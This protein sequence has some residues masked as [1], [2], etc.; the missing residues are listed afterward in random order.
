MSTTTLAEPGPL[1]LGRANVT[2]PRVLVAED[3]Q[4]MLALTAR[5]LRADGHEVIEACD[6]LELMYWADVILQ[7]SGPVPALDLIVTDLRM[8]VFSGQQCLEYLRSR[9][10]RTPVI[11]L[12]AFGDERVYAAAYAAGVREVLDK[13]LDLERLRIAVAQALAPQR[14]G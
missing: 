7:S 5:R 9:G 10:D 4:A 2:T 11:L 3:N 12:T 1:I 14:P 6:G 8:P 13:P